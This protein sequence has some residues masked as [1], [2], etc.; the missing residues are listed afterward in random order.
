MTT[1]TTGPA[2]A[3]GYTRVST[4]EQGISGLGLDAQ[5]D[6]ITAECT[7]RGWKLD[8][9]A[10]D[11][12]S[13][14]STNG[15][16]ELAAVLEALDRGDAGVL[17]VAKLD[18]LARSVLDFA[19]ILERAARRG[20]AVVILDAAVDTSTPQGALM[21]NVLAAF[22]QYERQLIG[23]RTRLALAAKRAQ[24]AR[25]G[26][27]VALPQGIRERIAN[28]RVA[29]RT[30]T[31]IANDLTANGV[32]TA[33]GGAQWHASTVRAVLASLELDAAMDASRVA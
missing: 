1:P 18:R 21:V 10:T 14:K 3:V 27:P 4:T 31:S 26:R 8:H 6:A 15:R 2:I 24:G 11:V 20:W 9:I 25:L 30:L 23:E 13:G 5:T 29:G 17:V 7:R 16:P 32:P 22:S 33:Q 19:T 12:A 28:E